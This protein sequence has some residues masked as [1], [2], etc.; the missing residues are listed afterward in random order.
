MITS[1]N[2]NPYNGLMNQVGGTKVHGDTNNMVKKE[3]FILMKPANAL[4]KFN[5]TIYLA[6]MKEESKTSEILKNTMESYQKVTTK[7]ITLSHSRLSLS[8]TISGQGPKQIKNVKFI[9]HTYGQA[10][11][12]FSGQQPFCHISSPGKFLAPKKYW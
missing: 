1:N 10:F 12:G 9:R 2:K 8:T 5:Q 4:T 11:R 6:N 3:N 7:T